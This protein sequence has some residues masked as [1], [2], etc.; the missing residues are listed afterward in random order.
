MSGAGLSVFVF[1]IYLVLTGAG[2]TFVPNTMLGL[3]G[4]ARTTEHWIRVMG[5]LVLLV[6]YYYIQAG[7]HDLRQF[8]PWTVV[9]RVS[10]FLAFAA[11]VLLGWAPAQLLIFGVVD[12]V[13]AVWTYLA[14]RAR[15]K[16]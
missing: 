12:L 9:A 16:G 5:W 11:F 8:L 13:G 3:F 15:P 4:L 14:L 10:V 7:R 6:G 2:F 1:G